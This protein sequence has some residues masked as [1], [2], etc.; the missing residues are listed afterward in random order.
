MLRASVIHQR[1]QGSDS[2]KH[3][4][5]QGQFPRARPAH[6]QYTFFRFLASFRCPRL[7][8]FVPNRPLTTVFAFPVFAPQLYRGP[9]GYGWGSS[10]LALLFAGIGFPVVAV[11][12]FFGERLRG[13]GKAGRRG[14][15]RTGQ[16]RRVCDMGER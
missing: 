16:L 15:E 7:P 5:E 2:W 14:E 1:S 12:W 6:T 13:V 10:L 4:Q 3:Q 9:L 8:S 11:L